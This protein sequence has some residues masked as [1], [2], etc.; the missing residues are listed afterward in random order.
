[1]HQGKRIAAARYGNNQWA[2]MPCQRRSKA[3]L[4]FF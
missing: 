2:I 4:D 1:M 3:L